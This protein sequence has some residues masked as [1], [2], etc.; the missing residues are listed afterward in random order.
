MLKDVL[1]QEYDQTVSPI[2]ETIEHDVKNFL[3]YVTRNLHNEIELD[4]N[5]IPIRLG[6]Q[7]LRELALAFEDGPSGLKEILALCVRL[8]VAKH[9]S[10][11]DKQCLVLDDPFVHVSSNRSEKM[12]EVINKLID[13][14]GLQIIVLTHRP[15]EFSGLEGKMIDI[16]SI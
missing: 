14:I 3:S 8:G 6:E 12:I 11:R 13:E 10:E 16:Q 5:L 4:K 1:E 9:L 7:G 2:F 15:M